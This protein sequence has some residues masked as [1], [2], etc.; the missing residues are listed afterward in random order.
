MSTIQRK[1]AR[2]RT[3]VASDRESGSTLS[4]QAKN[5]LLAFLIAL[6]IGLL[7]LLLST[8]LLLTTE[9]PLR[10]HGAVG[11][12][13]LLL[14]AL[15][16]GMIAARL[17]RSVPLFAGTATG[18]LLLLL[19]AAGCLFGSASDSANLWLMAALPA[20]SLLGALLAGR[21]RPPRRRRHK[22]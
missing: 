5:A 3:R 21:K 7:L 1:A 2:R 9:D 16:G 13:A 19:P 8:A 6:G 10:Y 4:V 14:A 22:K 15:A 17:S 12:T 11:K 20:L 18:L